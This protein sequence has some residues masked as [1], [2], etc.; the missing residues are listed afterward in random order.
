MFTR[1]YRCNPTRLKD[2]YKQGVKLFILI[3]LL[4]LFYYEVG[5]LCT[6]GQDVARLI[7]NYYSQ[8]YQGK[9]CSVINRENM[10]R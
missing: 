9:I 3:I 10:T 4:A 2:N 7:T 1:D 6:V 5:M 8:V